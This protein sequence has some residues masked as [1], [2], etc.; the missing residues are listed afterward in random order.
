MRL[1]SKAWDHSAAFSKQEQARLQVNFEKSNFQEASKKP[2][3]EIG[4]EKS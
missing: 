1:D 3:L 4:T 2:S